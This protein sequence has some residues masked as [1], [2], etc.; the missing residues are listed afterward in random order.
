MKIITVE[1]HFVSKKVNDEYIKYMQPTNEQEKQQFDFVNMT[2][3]EGPL[4]S[5]W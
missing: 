4:S 1:E 5:L 2:I 3:E